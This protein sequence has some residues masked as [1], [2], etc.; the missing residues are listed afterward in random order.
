MIEKK[1]DNS[2]EEISINKEFE[3]TQTITSKNKV[4]YILNNNWEY[5]PNS[6]QNLE[7]IKIVAIEN[8]EKYI[9]EVKEKTKL[10]TSYYILEWLISCSQLNYNICKWIDYMRINQKNIQYTIELLQYYYLNWI[11]STNEISLCISSV[12]ENTIWIILEQIEKIKIRNEKDFQYSISWLNKFEKVIYAKW[13]SMK[14]WKNNLN[15]Y[16]QN[17]IKLYENRK[18]VWEIFFFFFWYLTKK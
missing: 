6:N 3:L 16:E 9:K 15:I 1:W 8:K 5:I 12:L 4:N 13:L 11:L 2:N 18:P 17:F 14:K 10:I 7:D